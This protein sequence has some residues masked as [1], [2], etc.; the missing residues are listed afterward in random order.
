MPTL[1]YYAV[2]GLL[3]R[4]C[5]T[6]LTEGYENFEAE[7]HQIKFLFPFFTGI[8]IAPPTVKRPHALP[9]PLWK[10]HIYYHTEENIRWKMSRSKK[11]LIFKE[12]RGGT[13][14]SLATT[15]KQVLKFSCC[16]LGHHLQSLTWPHPLSQLLPFLQLVSLQSHVLHPHDYIL[17]IITN[18]SDDTLNPSMRDLR[19]M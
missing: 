9:R 15:F 14:I 10:D 17:Q 19:H 4:H 16:R 6:M 13:F 18:F 1:G 11:A 8:C 7:M 12:M 3:C 5:V 2:T